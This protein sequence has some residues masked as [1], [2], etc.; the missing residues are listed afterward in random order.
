MPKADNTSMPCKK[1]RVAAALLALFLGDFGA[2]KFYLGRPKLGFIYLALSWT[3]MPLIF[4][5]IEGFI[6]LYMSDE[7]FKT[8]YAETA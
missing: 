5:T 7:E 8:A 1:S 2:H 6:I 3:L 4:A